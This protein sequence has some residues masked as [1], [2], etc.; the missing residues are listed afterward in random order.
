MNEETRL[1]E[2]NRRRLLT[3]QDW[4]GID[5]SKPV[6]LRF[7]SSKEKENIGKRRRTTGKHGAALRQNN[8]SGLSVRQ[9][10]PAHKAFAGPLERGNNID[11]IR[12]RIGT[13]ALTN[14]YSAHTNDHVQS[15]ASS[16]P[17]LFD[18]EGPAAQQRETPD[19]APPVTSQ[20]RGARSVSR[21]TSAMP[22]ANSSTGE[23]TGHYHDVARH[24][25]PIPSQD[26]FEQGSSIYDEL[27]LQ[28]RDTTSI[29]QENESSSAGFRLM[30]RV[31]GNERDL[32]LVFGNSNFSAGGRGRIVSRDS[33]ISETQPLREPNSARASQTSQ[34]HRIDN[35]MEQSTI[36]KDSAALAIVD[37]ELWKSYLAI[38]DG[39][40]SH[41]DAA[42]EARNSMLHDH[43]TTQ[44]SNDAVTNWSQHATQGDQSH[45]DT[46]VSAS[47][48][49]LKRGVNKGLS[50][51]PYR[52]DPVRRGNVV[53]MKRQNLTED[54]KNWQAFVFGNDNNS[55]SQP[56]HDHTPGTPRLRYSGNTSSKYL[57][58]SAAV[59]TVSPPP[60]NIRFASYT[61]NE[62]QDPDVFAPP[63]MSRA[64]SPPAFH[65][66]VEELSD[67]EI[68]DDIDI[69]EP[70]VVDLQ[71]VT[72]ASLQNNA[73][74][75]SDLILSRMVG[76]TKT[77]RNSLGRPP[78]A[79]AAFRIQG[80]STRRFA[81]PS[82]IYDIPVSDD[83]ALNLV[84]PDET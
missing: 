35:D 15:Q 21:Q 49:S 38:S 58:F 18:Q 9:L 75:A 24:H 16:E 48:P 5:P 61:S 19:L 47:L 2:A 56:T 8:D 44:I 83:E 43:S 36:Y 70:D 37:E 31:E 34:I 51:Y 84:N 13:D 7:L 55:S 57:P 41:S 79:R 66:F 67:G 23:Q 25:E 39:R 73:P 27:E 69:D 65:G 42:V 12:I 74:A 71:S 60:R 78:P 26:A 3:Q 6:Q 52:G 82:P 46:S 10:R 4:V 80:T 68:D 64:T 20:S 22:H 33:D 63:S 50:A 45:I 40:S 53:D 17:M 11:N 32:H 28:N 1:L 81:E 59:S 54:E 29:H 14:T 76:S 72:P 30:Y 62:I 77:P